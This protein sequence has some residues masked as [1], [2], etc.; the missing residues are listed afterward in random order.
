MTAVLAMPSRDEFEQRQA[1][2]RRQ[3]A[4]MSLDDILGPD[5]GPDRQPGD[6]WYRTVTTERALEQAHRRHE[7]ELHRRYVAAAEWNDYSVADYRLPW[8]TRQLN[9]AGVAVPVV[10]LTIRDLYRRVMLWLVDEQPPS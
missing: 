8:T 2:R 4:N 3:Y 1:E 5:P 9:A 6:K 10:A 7:R